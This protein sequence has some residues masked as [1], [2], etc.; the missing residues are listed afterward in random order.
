MHKRANVLFDLDLESALQLRPLRLE[1][2]LHR[3]P[4]MGRVRDGSKPTPAPW[5]SLKGLP[6]AT[7]TS[8]TPV[9]ARTLAYELWLHCTPAT[10]TTRPTTA[11]VARPGSSSVRG[12]PARMVRRACP[13]IPANGSCSQAW[14]SGGRCRPALATPQT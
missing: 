11:T 10:F 3:L 5:L 1:R 4:S 9:H 12:K 7:S 13:S 14:S 2:Q 6:L 8:S